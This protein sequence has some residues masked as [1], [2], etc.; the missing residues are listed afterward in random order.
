MENVEWKH[1]TGKS[2]GWARGRAGGRVGQKARRMGGL[3][4]N[5]LL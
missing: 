4:G 2:G 1:K 5:V 3:G